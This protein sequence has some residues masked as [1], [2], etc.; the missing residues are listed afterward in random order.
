MECVF[1]RV[2]RGEIPSSTVHADDQVVAFMDIAP[3]TPGHL[4]VVPRAHA[5]GLGDLDPGDA[6]QMMVVA[7]R[8]AGALRTAL[9][10]AGVNLWPADGRAA[11]QE[12]FHSH[13]HVVPRNEGD[14]FTVSA[15]FQ[16][17]ARDVLDGLAA[18]VRDAL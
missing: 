14:G 11:G 5:A 3:A 1:C 16:Q 9:S 6:A 7:Q 12:V 13:L 8:L 15:T 17:P 2:T 18:Q 10:P 4:L